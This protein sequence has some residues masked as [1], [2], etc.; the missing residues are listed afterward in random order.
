MDERYRRYR[1]RKFREW[2]RKVAKHLPQLA[3][4]FYQ[5]KLDGKHIDYNKEMNLGR[6]IDGISDPASTIYNY[7]GERN[8]PGMQMAAEIILEIQ[9]EE[10][11]KFVKELKKC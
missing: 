5:A 8:A 11:F 10:L 1:E 9:V 4:D 2:K 3:M 6:V 7:Q